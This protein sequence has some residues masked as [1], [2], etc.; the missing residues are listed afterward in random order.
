MNCWAIPN[1]PLGGLKIE[2]RLVSAIAD[3][4]VRRSPRSGQMKIAHRFIGE[5]ASRNEPAV[6][7]TDG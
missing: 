3:K 6:R 4:E 2:R 1:R 7:E 5:I